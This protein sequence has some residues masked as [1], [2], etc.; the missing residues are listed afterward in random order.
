MIND[1]AD[2]SGAKCC[3]SVSIYKNQDWIEHFDPDD[4]LYDPHDDRPTDGADFL[5]LW[6]ELPDDD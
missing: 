5:H 2:L 1:D 4:P 6:D 3:A